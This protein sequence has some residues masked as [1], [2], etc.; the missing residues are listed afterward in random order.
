M[1]PIEDKA[2]VSIDF[3]DKFYMGKFEQES[4][5]E[6]RAEGDGLAF[7]LVREGEEKRAVS[8]HLHH[9]VL[10]GILSDWAASLRDAE[11]VDRAHAKELTDALKAVEKALARR[12][13]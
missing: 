4:F 1:H 6:A 5:Y 9:Y 12:R 8:V 11:P 2:E 13:K 7:R 10:A 3:P